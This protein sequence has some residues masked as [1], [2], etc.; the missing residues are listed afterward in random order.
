M[1]VTNLGYD[2]WFG[3]GDPSDVTGYPNAA[4]SGPQ[5]R[6]AGYGQPPNPYGL[7]LSNL[8][9]RAVGAGISLPGFTFPF[10]AISNYFY[11]TTPDDHGDRPSDVMS[12]E[13][14]ARQQAAN[15]P[16]PLRQAQ[17]AA[18]AASPGGA[19]PGAGLSAPNYTNPFLA[20][21]AT[22]GAGLGAPM[23]PAPHRSPAAAATAAPSPSTSSGAPKRTPGA[24][25]L[26]YYQ[27]ND[28]FP[29]LSH[30]V[31]GG[32]KTPYISALNLGSLFGGGGQQ[33]A[34][35]A[36]PAAAPAAAPGGGPWPASEINQYLAHN[37][38]GHLQM[39]PDQ[40]ATYMKT[41]PWL[42][43][44]AGPAGRQMTPPQLAQAVHRPNWWRQYS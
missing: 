9:N 13:E 1:A 25:N 27:P 11:P 18:P 2:D 37:A 29:L 39:S 44:L 3:T 5:A 20:A 28:R 14:L 40:L 42:Q 26:G 24:P 19:G 10:S 7:S 35:Q 21:G 22:P 34:P 16:P 6:A 30:D 38:P 4:G 32:G 17:E 31:S 15:A 41:Q 8:H 36:A 33:A 12:P 23:L 43:N